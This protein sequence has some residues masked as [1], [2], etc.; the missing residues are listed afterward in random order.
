MPIVI[1]RML[2]YLKSSD[3]ELL[4]TGRFDIASAP[5]R[6]GAL[7]HQ[8][9]HRLSMDM[10]AAMRVF[11]RVVERRS[12]SAAARDLGMGQP[13]V[14]ER[15]T[16]LEAHLGQRLL[17]RNTRS[18]VPTDIGATFHERSRKA[19]DA[20]AYAESVG[21]TDAPSLRGTLRVAAPHGLGEM[22]LP[23]ILMRFRKKHPHL[24][25]DLFLNDRIADPVTEGADLS[26]R[27]GDAPAGGC[28]SERIG[29]VQR[30]LVA[31]PEY[32][33]TCR[34]LET[35]NDLKAHPFLR[36]A[37]IFNDNVLPLQR[38]DDMI[39]VAINTTWTVSNWRPLHSL[40]LA[41]AGIGVLQMPSC[42]EALAAGHLKRVLPDYDVPGFN[43][44]LLYARSEKVPDKT[45]HLASFLREELGIFRQ[46]DPQSASSTSLNENF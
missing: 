43:L 45:R 41:G 31:S 27:L 46:A 12:L 2:R 38:R 37:G 42:A 11:V 26:V 24:N 3:A 16:R 17:Y 35:P 4:P 14:S 30:M 40:L 21:D 32:L 36:V 25:I 33:T 22:V 5:R 10:F 6:A 8:E 44:R 20:A 39:R 29:L 7:S 15:I 19:L 23:P 28:V 9:F 34:M 18:I 13:A 1:H